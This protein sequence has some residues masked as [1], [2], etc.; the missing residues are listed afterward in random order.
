MEIRALG[1]AYP[2][3]TNESAAGRQENRR[4]EIVVSDAQGEFP[5]S[6]RRVAATR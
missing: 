4:V 6:A 2:V 3:A 1:E 5:D